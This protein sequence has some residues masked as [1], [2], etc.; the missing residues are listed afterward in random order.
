MHKWR[1]TIWTNF[2]HHPL[3]TH[4]HKGPTPQKW[5]SQNSYPS[6]LNL[7]QSLRPRGRVIG[8]FARDIV[9]LKTC[10]RYQKSDCKNLT[11]VRL[12]KKY[13]CYNNNCATNLRNET[14]KKRTKEILI[15]CK[16]WVWCYIPSLSHPWSVVTHHRKCLTPPGWR[17]W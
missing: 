13:S 16:I 15:T 10:L 1:H 9:S 6:P 8:F 5:T 4:H 3:V 14:C 12:A 2:L 17:H 7:R 11:N